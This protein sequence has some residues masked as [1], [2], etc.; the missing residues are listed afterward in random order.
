MNYL[1][2]ILSGVKEVAIAGH[3]RPDGD[4]VGSCLGLYNY[5]KDNFGQIAVK[6]Y[7]EAPSEVFGFLKG[8][9]EIC[10]DYEEEKTYDVFFALDCG[11]KQRLGAAVT[12][13]DTAKH[14]VCIDHHISNVGFAE[15]NFIKGE[16][17]STCEFLCEFME[18]EKIAV[19]AAKCLY[20]GIVHDTGVFQYSSTTPKTLNTAGMLIEKGFDFTKIID[21]TIYQKTY[22]QQQIT[23]RALL[24]SM[25][26]LDGKVIF[27]V[28]H[29]KD[30]D[31]YGVSTKDL[32]GIVSQLRTTVG[33][34][35]AIFLYEL[36]AQ[37]YKVSMRSN[38]YVNV[39]EIAGYFG[40][41]GHVRAAGCT[42]QGSMYDVINNLTEHI[43]KQILASDED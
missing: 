7:I 38:S 42:M 4:C 3:V 19:E 1:E 37:I 9:D 16:L 36:E 14:T 6:V 18:A 27:S 31:F 17:S 10:Y 5:I 28:V 25:M 30:M 12:Y 23:G 20:T 24:E 39:S 34:E 43:E 13:F 22:K 11:D 33:V 29:K 32:E 26:V 41:G 15:D 8:V 2:Q 21:Q 35:V 40:G